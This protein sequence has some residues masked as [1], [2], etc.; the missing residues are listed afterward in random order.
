MR[1]APSGSGGHLPSGDLAPLR[2]APSGS[3]GHLPS[4]DLAPLRQGFTL[5]ELL[6][7]L[8]LS[9]AVLVALMTVF[10]SLLR[11]HVDTSLKGEVSGWTIMALEQ[12]S[13][14]IEEASFINVPAHGATGD[15]LGG[16][17][18]FSPLQFTSLG[19]GRLNTSLNVTAFYYC[20][21]PDIG[22]GMPALLRIAVVGPGLNCPASIP[23][24]GGCILGGNTTVLV[25]NFHYRDEDLTSSPP[26]FRNRGDGIE[27]HFAVG[28]GT[29]PATGAAA[30]IP[31]P[32]SL[33]VDT[34]LRSNRQYFGSD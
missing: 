17:V 29:R 26:I 4:G 28:S 23:N 1:R 25:R 20:R 6:L 3:G 31:V 10:A 27:M 9:S 21:S 11:S 32:V 13:Q 16:C 14:E 24:G 34:F 5:I 30:T 18:N 2:R 12:M 22:G 33:K 15:G 19:E 7:A 8:S